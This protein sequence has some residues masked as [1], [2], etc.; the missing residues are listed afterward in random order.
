ML[1]FVNNEILRIWFTFY[2]AQLAQQ[3]N[4]VIVVIILLLLLSLLSLLP[5]LSL[6]LLLLLLLLLSSEVNA[7]DSFQNCELGKI[8]KTDSTTINNEW[9]V[10]LEGSVHKMKS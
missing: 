4:K 3:F 9:R 1:A 6:L 2:N 7:P 8:E 5:L 10:T